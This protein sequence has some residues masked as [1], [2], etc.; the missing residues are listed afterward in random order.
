MKKE[1]E[2]DDTSARRM[3]KGVQEKKKPG[4]EDAGKL[5]MIKSEES[6]EEKRES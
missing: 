4:R 3:K 5:E 1:N 2:E 6:E